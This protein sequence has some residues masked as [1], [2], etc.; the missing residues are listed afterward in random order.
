M[1]S[2]EGYSL[3]NP[4]LLRFQDYQFQVTL[5]SGA[6]MWTTRVDV[7]QALPFTQIRDVVTPYGL[8]RD[9]I[10]LPGEVV[11]AMA[12]SIT[13]VQQAYTPS[14][15]LNPT[16]LTFVIDEGRGVSNPKSVQVTNNGVLG[17]LLGVSITSSAPYVFPI[18]ANVNGLAANESG[19]FD[20]SA[21]STALLAI[22]SPYAVTLTVQGPGATNSPQMIPVNVIVR[23]KATIMTS[24]LAL[25]FNVTAPIGGPFPPIPSQQFVLSNSGPSN[26]VLDYQIRKLTGVPWVVS[27]A[28]VFGSL[29]GGDSQPITVVVAPQSM[30]TTGTFTETLRITGYS[31]NMTQDV[32]VTLNIT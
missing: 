5:T 21:D 20:V 6:W 30:M 28:P 16:T 1:G 24:S 29:N 19:T 17:S 10:P 14:I 23:P 15:L 7:S 26:S 31:S 27:F 4:P 13:T 12:A 2:G 22:G 11:Q 3:P 25:T 32:T 18:P 9:S 8:F